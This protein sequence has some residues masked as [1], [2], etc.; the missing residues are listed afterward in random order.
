MLNA[1]T[2]R[3]AHPA[4]G[5]NSSP[6]TLREFVALFCTKKRDKRSGCGWNV[7]EWQ[8]VKNFEKSAQNYFGRILLP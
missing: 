1:E 3:I 4:E 5:K 6:S 8:R 2:S 7:V